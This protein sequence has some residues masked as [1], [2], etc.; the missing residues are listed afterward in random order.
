MAGRQRS[1]PSSSP[2]ADSGR[3]T[4]PSLNLDPIQSMRPWPVVVT[5]C[6]R[7]VE[8]PALPAVDWLVILMS[9]EPNLDD[10]FPGLLSTEDADWVEERIV[11]G[12]LGLVEFQGLIFNIIE[13]VSARKWWVALRLIDVARRSWD[14]IG[15]EMLLRGVDA[16]VVSLS[17]WLDVL[18]ITVLKN[19]DPKDVAMFN[20]R[21]EAAPEQEAEPEDLEMSR[22]AFMALGGE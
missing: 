3:I 19:T 15:S 8:I 20:L 9:P 13:T 1:A 5:C 18:L 6:G 2:T 22:S 4:V 14:V 7:D 21:L 11:A 16:A 12:N 10:L 17:A